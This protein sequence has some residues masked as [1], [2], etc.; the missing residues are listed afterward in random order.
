MICATLLLGYVPYQ[1]GGQAGDDLISKWTWDEPILDGNF[2]S[3]WSSTQQYYYSIKNYEDAGNN[4]SMTMKFLNNEDYLYIAITWNDDSLA[5]GYDWIGL[6]FDELN[7]ETLTNSEEDHI[8]IGY[9]GIP[10]IVD[11]YWQDSWVTDTNQSKT[12][13]GG[14]SSFELKI[15]I[16]SNAE[17]ED[18]D[19]VSAGDTVGL[20]I[21]TRDGEYDGN[22]P[23]MGSW[24]TY[25]YGPED[26]PS[27]WADLHL[28]AKPDLDFGVYFELSADSFVPREVFFLLTTITNINGT[29]II[30]SLNVTLVLP[31]GIN[32]AHN[33]PVTVWLDQLNPG[34]NHSYLWT[35]R[36]EDIGTH[37]LELLVDGNG[38]PK[39]SQELD[40]L[41]GPVVAE[42]ET[43]TVIT[44]LEKTITSFDT[45]TTKDIQFETSTKTVPGEETLTKTATTYEVKTETIE[46]TKSEASFQ[47][48]LLIVFC[49]ISVHL[50]IKWKN[51]NIV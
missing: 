25:V 35:L 16:G 12:S 10:S 38:M 6:Y 31:V 42:T 4:Q 14:F 7:D 11:R 33:E 18:L 17:A 36:A 2:E 41:V 37:T 40:V 50:S 30:Y 34:N 29:G 48:G 23:S 28:A 1:V 21:I 15:P 8:S 9:S 3:L 13:G 51:K 20:G 47:F 46:E 27:G 39:V 44:N 19:L 26:D 5:S 22:P 43:I 49:A 24:P 45:S 32:M